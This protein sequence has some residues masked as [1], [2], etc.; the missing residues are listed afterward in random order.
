MSR[1][2]FILFRD[3]VNGST[4][5]FADPLKLICVTEPDGLLPALHELEEWKRKGK[6]L[7][8]LMSYEA[9]YIF[10]PKLAARLTKARKSPLMCFGVFNAPLNGSDPRLNIPEGLPDAD[11]FLTDFV[12]G[13]DFET[14][15]KKFEQLH[16]HIAMG[17]CYQA[18]LTM[19]VNCRWQGNPL[20]AFYSLTA[21]QPVKYGAYVDLGGPILLSRSPELFFN[22]DADGYIETHPMKGTAKRG[23]TA[24]EDE[25]IKQAMLGDEKTQAENRMIVD[26]LRNDISRLIEV[27]SLDVPRLFDIET[28]PTVHQMVSHVRGKLLHDVT[29]GQIFESLFPCGSVTGAPKMWA[30]KILDELEDVARDAYCGTIGYIK[31]D[32]SM[33]FNVPIRTISLFEDGKATFNVGGGIV[34]DS[35]AEAEYQE[36]LLKAKFAVGERSLLAGIKPQETV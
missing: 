2:P 11:S 19:P 16:R 12:V 17:D 29:V 5:A 9:G 24:A 15:S 35:V 4:L 22:V 1:D 28:Y 13:W 30:M 27:G 10:E 6:F 18:N 32:G 3:D 25:A 26:L 8:G 20:Q 34:F 31:P 7:A 33:R 14:Y 21:R 23:R 36:C